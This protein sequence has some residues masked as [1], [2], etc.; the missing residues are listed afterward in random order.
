MLSCFVV[1]LVGQ[2]VSGHLQYN[3]EQQGHAG[4]EI[5]FMQYLGTDHFLE[6]TMENWE[7]E[8][9]QMFVYVLFTAFLYQKGSSES[10]K[11]DEA[12]PVDKEP[13]NKRLKR[14]FPGLCGLA[15]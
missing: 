6:A 10:K 11:L 13:S 5:N 7:S 12:E 4:P 1:L 9:L 15:A 14:T 8:F 2:A 3:E